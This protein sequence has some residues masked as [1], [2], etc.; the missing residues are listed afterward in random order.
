MSPEVEKRLKDMEKLL[1]SSQAQVREA[2]EKRQQAEQ[3][4]R[5]EKGR[6]ALTVAFGDKLR[7][8]TAG[9]VV[10]LLDGAYRRLGFTDE[11]E[12][13]LIVDRPQYKG[14]PIEKVALPLAEAVPLF[15]QSQEAAP[16]LPAPG[17]Q[18]PKNGAQPTIPRGAPLKTGETLSDSDRS[19]NAVSLMQRMGVDPGQLG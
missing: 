19:S 14:G 12:P 18:P 1:E 2:E 13:T 17:G 16:F 15:L 10:D 4:Q 11:G 6:N 3:A 9:I 8:G 7:A 5:R